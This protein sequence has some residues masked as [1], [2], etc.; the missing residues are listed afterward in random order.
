LYIAKYGKTWYQD[1]FDAELLNSDLRRRLADGVRRLAAPIDDVDAFI[2]SVKPYVV[3]RRL[4][5]TTQVILSSWSHG[6]T[7]HGLFRKLGEH[8]CDIF[9]NW[10]EPFINDMVKVSLFNATWYISKAAPAAT[11]K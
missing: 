7:Y 6:M 5:S 9:E 1:K 2:D 10:L 11:T 4:H 8:D 3:P